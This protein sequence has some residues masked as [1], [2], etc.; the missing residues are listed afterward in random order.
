MSRPAVLFGGPSPE[1]DIS[2]LTG[3]QA[4]RTLTEAGL[5]VD[6]IYWAKSADWYLVDAGMEAADF[7]DGAPAKARQLRF[8]AAPG[9]GFFLKKKALALSAIVNCC[10]GGPGEDGTLQA[11]LDLAG[12]RYT[13]PDAAGSVLGMDKFAF[14]AVVAAAGLP[15][16]PR[17]LVGPGQTP[18]FDGPYIAKPRFGGS[19][20]GI[21]VV[22]DWATALALAT[23][24]S[25]MRRGAVVEP[26]LPDSRDLNISVRTFPQFELS[27]IEAPIRADDSARIY[28]YRQKYLAGGGLDGS[29]REIPADIPAEWAES[30]RS[31]SAIVAGLVRIRSVARIDFLQDGDKLYVNEINTIPGSLSAYLWAEAG[32]SRAQ[33]LRDMVT[34]AEQ[35]P[36]VAFT[37]AGADGVALRSASSIASKL[38]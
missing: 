13:G 24:S 32:V 29:A 14:G 20:I 12:I 38:G 18:A 10:H 1:H 8:E 25:H 36:A 37:T 2:I 11:A 26:F 15:T 7:A 6:A 17:V 21:E 22:E 27:P 28:D 5:A 23:S 19:S 4:A 30:I 31:M 9:G 3:L 35:A 33:L 34:E 16:L